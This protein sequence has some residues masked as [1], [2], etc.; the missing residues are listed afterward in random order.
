M[1]CEL[2]VAEPRSRSVE[3]SVG[4][5][6]DSEVLDFDLPIGFVCLPESAG[7]FSLFS[8]PGKCWKT[9]WVLEIC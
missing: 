5:V 3:M 4:V 6:K 7:D 9:V 8:K 1:G 2:G